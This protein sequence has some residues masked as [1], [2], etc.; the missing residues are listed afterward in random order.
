MG[1]DGGLLVEAGFLDADDVGDL[2]EA[3]QSLGAH[4]EAELGGVVEHDGE[5]GVIRQ[6]LHVLK[7]LVLGFGDHVG[8]GDHEEVDSDLLGVAGEGQHFAGRGV[9]DVGAGEPPSDG[10]AGDGFHDV[11]S[12]V[13][14][15]APELAHGPGAASAA[16]AEGLNVAD[17]PAHSF[18]VKG[19]VGRERGDEGAPLPAQVFPSPILRFMFLVAR[20][21][22]HLLAR[23]DEGNADKRD[24]ETP[25][26]GT[27]K[28]EASG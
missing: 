19:L 8:R 16:G 18:F 13:K 25:S 4:D 7:D 5:I 3:V 23:V 2:A 26:D 27:G 1:L 15:E 20:H 14:S 11:L 22:I 24:G 28:R 9:G 6:Q 10:L 12:L 17:V 21:D